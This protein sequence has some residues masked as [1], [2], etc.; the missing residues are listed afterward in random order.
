[1]LAIVF[2]Q[3]PMSHRTDSFVLLSLILRVPRAQARRRAITC[4]TGAPPNIIPDPPSR[5]TISGLT[6]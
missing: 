5:Q 4:T 1:M 2:E 6:H 3:L